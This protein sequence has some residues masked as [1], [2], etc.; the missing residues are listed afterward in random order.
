[1]TTDRLQLPEKI[2]FEETAFCETL[3]SASQDIGIPLTQT[4][5]VQCVLYAKYLL[6]TNLHT[7]LTRIT[8]SREMAIKHFADSL[9]CFSLPIPTPANKPSLRVCDVGT[10]A[11]FPGLVLKILYPGIAVTLLDSLQK[12]LTFLEQVSSELAFSDVR[13]VHARAEDAGRNTNLRDQFDL[14]TARAVAALP[15]LLEWCAP[16][17]K[18]GGHF[19]AMKSG[20]IDSELALSQNAATFLKVRLIQDKSLVLPA[21]SE[22]ELP[23]E[24]R[25]LLYQK[26]AVSPPQ[27]PRSAA[28]IKR[29]PL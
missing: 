9:T 24:R 29:K 22:A 19:I 23:A 12:R 8:E 6:E 4:Q 7:N 26:I 1:M 14:V 18:V 28:E 17:V 27:F 10:G 3:Q 20:N 11:G 2:V 21:T 15:T 5:I 13:F 16:L 25:L